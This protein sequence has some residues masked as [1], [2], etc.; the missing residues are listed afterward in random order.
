MQKRGLNMNLLISVM[1]NIENE[2]T[3]APKHR[4]HFLKGDYIGYKDCHIQPDWLL[5]YQIQDNT[6]VFERTGTH[7]DLFG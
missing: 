2:N 6:V 4:D 7:S 3:L 5:I 1:K